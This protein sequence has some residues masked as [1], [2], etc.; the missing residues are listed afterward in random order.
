LLFEEFL[1]YGGYPKVIL[2]ETKEEKIKIIGEIYRSYVE[3]DISRCW[4]HSLR[5]AVEP[6]C[7]RLAFRLHSPPGLWSQQILAGV[8]CHIR[9]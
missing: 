1:N 2:E 7:R 3:K 4:L 6:D 8:V 5:R 9:D